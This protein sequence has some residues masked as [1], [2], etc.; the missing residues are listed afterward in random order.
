MK[1]DI[2]IGID[3]STQST[4]AIAWTRE[5]EALAEGRAPIPMEMP[6]PGHVEQHAGD[7]WKSARDALRELTGR[8]DASR[9]AGMA[10]SN[11]RETVAFLDAGGEPVR[12]AMVW[13]DQRATEEV[14]PF[15][16]RL[17]ADRLHRITGKPIDVTPVAYRLAWLRR[18]APEDLLATALITDVQGLL[19]LRLTGAATVSWTSAD[20]FGVL[21]IEA[22]EWSRPILDA[23]DLAQAQ[24]G[25]LVPPGAA[26]GAVTEG[27]A[28]ETG[29]EAGTPLFAGGGDG[30][31]AGLGVNAVRPGAVYLN[32]GTAIITGTWSGEPN[33]S[34]TWRTV[35]SPTGEGY[36]LEGCQR[37]GT[38]LIDWFIDNFA[39]GRADPGVFAELEAGA[40]ALPVGSEGVVVCPYL[41]GCMDPHWDPAARASVSGL[42]PTHGKR[43]VYRAILEALTLET[44]RTVAAWDRSGLNP[45]RIVAVGGGAQNRLWTRMIADA[46][47]LPLAVSDSLEASSLGA[48]MS[49][50]VGCGWFAGFAQAAAAMSGVDRVVRPDPTARQEWDAATRRQA[51]AYRPEW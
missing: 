12:P 39:G 43:H 9:V 37:A 20:P 21:D 15:S 32:L 13:L 11:Q 45:E 49:A 10:V 47:G 31:C 18:H 17:G 42:T 28:E 14:Q 22:K 25:A 29:L 8:I 4:K 46:T 50:A 26:M 48:G 30:Q 7:W 19:A 23:L 24:F 5:G 35:I 41:S 3:S 2:V 6:H 40:A 33:I 51:G 1:P 38:L 16:R 36:F 44:A 27:A 34:K